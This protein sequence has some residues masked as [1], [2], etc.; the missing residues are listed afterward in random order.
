M[1]EEDRALPAVIEEAHAAGFFEE[2][3][4]HDFQPDDVFMWS[5]ETTEWWRH[6]TGDP[7]AGVPPF[8]IF[9]RDGSGGLVAFWTRTPGDAI[10]NAPIVF[11][12]AEGEVHV[13]ARDL[14]D[15]LWL[16]ANGV[17]PLETVDGLHRVP[18]PIQELVAIAQ[19]H[20]GTALKPVEALIAAADAELPALTAFINSATE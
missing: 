11:L 8:R 19:R 20:T 2:H 15:Y 3:D 1:A 5:G 7:A 18:E 4:G 14:G 9:G 17:G 16:L 12:G 10:E 13:I 6:W